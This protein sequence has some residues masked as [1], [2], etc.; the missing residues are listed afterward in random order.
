[1][2]KPTPI[3]KEA[4]FHPD[5]FFFSTTDKRGVIEY[6]NDVF[7]RIS[8]YHR[9]ELMGKPH[10]VIRHPDMPKC[11]FKIFWDMLKAGKPI[12]AYVKNM[13]ADGSYYWV[14]AF[15]FP[16]SDTGY[17]SVRFKPTSEFFNAVKDL[18]AETLKE[19]KAHD[20]EH[21][22]NFLMKKLSELGFRD[23]EQYM[24][25]AAV[26]ELN[27]LEQ[28]LSHNG[29]TAAQKNDRL[30]T[31]ISD[32]K[33]STVQSINRSFEK[34]EDFQ[35][36][37]KTFTNTIHHLETEFKKLKFLSVNM[38]IL[39]NKFGS[40]AASL[41]VISE[42]FSGLATQIEEQLSNFSKFTEELL[43]IIEMCTMHLIA[44][45]T[46]M[47]MVDFFVKES[48]LKNSFDEMITNKDMFT[49]LFAESSDNLLKE[50]TRLNSES[51]V[52]EAQIA[53]IQK[54]INGLEIVKQTGAIESARKDNVKAAF[55]VY[56]QEMNAFTALLRTSIDKLGKART[57]LNYSAL[58]IQD[59]T[60][61][62]RDKV[63]DLFK[64]VIQRKALS[65]AA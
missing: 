12:A 62:I 40:D 64:L 24:I 37:S 44:L 28:Y 55:G 49:S 63:D 65:T 41:S 58:E 10:N 9:D 43:K 5:E 29:S 42:H 25:H 30:A 61:V 34:I 32:V 7:V 47:N 59:S 17:L 22:G 3:N 8:G 6:G 45:K 33:E 50:I 20:M 31:L 46:Q 19:E 18:Y 36:S 54:F 2:K 14:F 52:I 51:R 48:I 39:A 13:A 53:D 1:M 26:T 38:S 23:Y 35:T 16:V 57:T 27:S 11:V 15:A 60:S 4:P 21:A 56:L